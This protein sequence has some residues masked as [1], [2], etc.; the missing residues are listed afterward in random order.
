MKKL[1]AYELQ[2]AVIAGVN[3]DKLQK[4]MLKES[5]D[6]Q[7]KAQEA[8]FKAEE[9]VKEEQNRSEK[10]KQQYITLGVT[11]VLLLTLIFSFFIFKAFTHIKKNNKIISE[12]KLEVEKQKNLVEEKHKDITDSINYAQRIQSALI[13]SETN[14]Q[15]NLKEAFVIFKPR[16]IVSGD[17]YWY[18]EHEGTKIVALADCTG[19]GVPG[20]FMS[21]IGI[22]LLNQ[23]VN[24]KGITSPAL[25]LNNLR[26][27][28]IRALSTDAGD[29]RDGMDM[30][31]IAFNG[32]ELFYA[33]ANSKALLIQNGAITELKPNKQPIGLYENEASFTEQRIKLT[34]DLKIYLFS[35]GIVDQFGGTNGK[36]VKTKLFKEWILSSSTLPLTEQKEVIEQKLNQWTSGLEQTDDISL[37]GLKPL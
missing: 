23:I 22:T 24:E 26:K 27:E 17:F 34:D 36:K 20:A 5:Y 21:M 28:V 6:S 10:R 30:A 7:L 18:S 1:R 25:I 4:T 15:R 12:Q 14:L 8:I 29:K 3:K 33:G 13:I 31:I 16:D 19:H 2:S 35:D 32:S 9:Q 37:L 11:V